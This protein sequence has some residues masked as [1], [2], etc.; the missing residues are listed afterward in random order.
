M[1]KEK[2]TKYYCIT[3]AL[4]NIYRSDTI[5]QQCSNMVWQFQTDRQL[6]STHCSFTPP[7]QMTRKRKFLSPRC[8]CTAVFS[9]LKSAVPEHTQ[10]CS[11][12]SSGQQQ[13]PSGAAGAC[14]DLLLWAL[15]TE[16]TLPVL[17]LQNLAA[18]LQYILP[19]TSMKIMFKNCH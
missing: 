14:S 9:F 18:K 3:S 1:G 15:P 5:S 12:L 10:Q 19:L 2:K 17:C 4:N 11:C 7:P 8:C 6:S 16:D 13:V